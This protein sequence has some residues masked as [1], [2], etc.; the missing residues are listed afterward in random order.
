MSLALAL[1]ASAALAA[2]IDLQ[3]LRATGTGAQSITVVLT[4]VPGPVKPRI[5]LETQGISLDPAPIGEGMYAGTIKAEPRRFAHITVLDTGVSPPESLYSG[6]V[7]LPDQDHEILAYRYRTW[8]FG[9]KQ[10]REVL[11]VPLV[12]YTRIGMGMNENVWIHTAGAWAALGL[13]YAVAITALSLMRRRA[14]AA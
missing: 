12:P 9:Q 10:R 11:R 14:D 7:T 3:Q 2:E 5:V 6:L 4:E 1:A 8:L 13:L